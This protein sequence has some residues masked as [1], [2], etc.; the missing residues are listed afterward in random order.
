ML[1]TLIVEDN[2]F[3]RDTLKELLNRHFPTMMVGEAS[4]G[5]EAVQKIESL[6]PDL[7][8]MDIRLPDVSG[9]EL[10]RKIK[11]KNRNIKVLILTGHH[12]PEY[13]EMATRYGADGFLVKG[14]SS[15]EFLSMVE[16]FF[17]KAEESTI[18]GEE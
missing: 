15:K 17:P 14:E 8:V 2:R 5:E 7:I 11:E 12:Y 16:S 1:K 18:A 9:L 6:Q 3:N 10:T 13:K 4:S